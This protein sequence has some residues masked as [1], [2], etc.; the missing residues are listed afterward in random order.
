MSDPPSRSPRGRAKREQILSAAR[1][2]FLSQGYA[3]T[4]TDALAA[5]AGVS[6]QTL[7]AY[8]P[9]KTELLA[10]VVE[11]EMGG[12]AVGELDR[13]LT[14]LPELRAHLLGFALGLTRHL[15]QPDAL[16]LLRLLLGEAAHLPEVRRLTRQAIP[17]RLLAGAGAL[18]AAAHARGLIDAPEP[19]L[20]A[21]MLIG[22]VMSFV[23]L[24]GFFSDHRPEPPSEATLAKLID[25][26]LQSVEV[27][28]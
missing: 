14:S 28:P 26:F 6:K 27:R 11:R 5:G 18:L 24:D 9:G 17:A 15:L 7:Y 20:S 8:F 1:A 13:A 19:D 22:P 16:A 4:S 10:A 3:R 2:Q 25:L 23:L 12:L 21:R